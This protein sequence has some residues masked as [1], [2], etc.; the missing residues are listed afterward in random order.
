VRVT[1]D[2]GRRDV[3]PQPGRHNYDT[4]NDISWLVDVNLPAAN[5]F[6]L[7]VCNSSGTQPCVNASGSMSYQAAK[8]WVAA[9]NAANYLG[10]TNWQLPTTPFTDSCPFVGP[11]GESFGFSC[12]ATAL[13][14]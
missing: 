6:G 11:Q 10:H 3:G 7:P 1:F 14:S 5:R 12:S 13:G 2:A 9:M 4:V 8:A